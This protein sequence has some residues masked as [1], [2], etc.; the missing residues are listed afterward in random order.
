MHV[1]APPRLSE[2]APALSFDSYQWIWPRSALPPRA[3]I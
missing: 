3:E 1:Y 2:D